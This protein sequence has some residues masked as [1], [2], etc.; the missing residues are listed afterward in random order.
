MLLSSELRKVQFWQRFTVLPFG[1]ARISKLLIKEEILEV[2][3]F[4]VLGMCDQEEEAEATELVALLIS[5]LLIFPTTEN[6]ESDD[7]FRVSA[8]GSGIFIPSGG[9]WTTIFVGDESASPSSSC[10]SEPSWMDSQSLKDRSSAISSAIVK[11]MRCATFVGVCMKNLFRWGIGWQS[12][13]LSASILRRCNGLC[14]Y[15]PVNC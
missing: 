1:P 4:L 6:E 14:T 15:I 12:S 13:K 5:R 8:S 7:P 3:L 11:R 9:N 2:V 10:F